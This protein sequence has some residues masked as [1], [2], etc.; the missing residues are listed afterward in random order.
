[1]PADRKE[2]TRRPTKGPSAQ[3]R[4]RPA[5]DSPLKIA[6]PPND[7]PDTAVVSGNDCA[8]MRSAT[9]MLPPRRAHVRARGRLRRAGSAD[10]DPLHGLGEPGAARD[11]E[12][13]HRGV[14]ET[15]SADPRQAHDG[16][17]LKLSGQAP[18]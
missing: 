2:I 11:G 5:L 14:R 13:D 4:R 12:A 6:T 7:P 15:A 9:P 8:N 17:G 1:K 3:K 18:P 16:P 10:A